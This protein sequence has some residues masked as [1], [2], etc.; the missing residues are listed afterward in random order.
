VEQTTIERTWA[1]ERE[2]TG[3]QRAAL[4]AWH[5]AHGEVVRI[6]NVMVMTGLAERSA[7]HLMCLLSGVLPIYRDVA[8]FWQVCLLREIP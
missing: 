8:G 4:V 7:Q 1:E 5:L 6:E 2:Y 3:Q